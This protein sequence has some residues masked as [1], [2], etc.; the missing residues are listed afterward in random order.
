MRNRLALLA[1]ALL[2][3]LTG[4]AGAGA[5][6]AGGSTLVIAIVSNPQMND[7]IELS[8]QFEAANPGVKL[9]FV[10]LPENQARA[11]ITSSVATQGGEFDVV[12]ISN[13]ETPQWA[14]NGWLENLQPYVDG[15]PGYDPADFIPSIKDSLSY[16]GSMYAVP[17]YGESSFLAYR[18]DLF[19]KAGLTMPAH[20]TWQQ[21]ADFA[22]KL[23][24]K[25]AGVSGICL[26]GKPGWGENLA[27]FDTVANTFGASW[28]DQNWNA[29]LTSPQ[30]KAAA[31]FYVNL[32]RQHGEV[33]AS[34]AGFSECGTRY[35]QGQAAMW[36]DATV[37][38]GTNE[39]PANSKV[40]GKSGYVAAPVEQT[41]ASGWLYTWSLAIPKVAKNK[42]DSW[43][44]LDWMTNKQFVQM[45]GK[46]DGWNAVPP[47][48]RKSTYQIPD[49]QQAAKAYAQ[50]TL[51]SIDA[52]KLENVHTQPVPYTGIQF[53][54]IPEFQDLGTRVSQELSAA[55]AGQISVDEA[56]EQSQKYAQTVGDSYRETK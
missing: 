22:A 46:A 47:G 52:A 21:I 37:M 34:S 51:D 49:Y 30:F 20:P 2:L 39:D 42:Q 38:A 55:I 48:V 11:K 16:N 36:Y 15:T 3:T 18:K 1:A 28:F 9:K 10:S 4:C 41:K 54:G 7:A 24:D 31:N 14:A 32:V 44:F 13:Y 6:G 35:A 53:V 5:I 56:L 26:R 19:E 25:N 8:D 27:P 43:K 45:V 23:D 17:F 33:G 40:V 50:P 12:M 29:Q